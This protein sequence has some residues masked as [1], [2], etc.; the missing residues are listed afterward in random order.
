MDAVIVKVGMLVL[1]QFFYATDSS[2]K[3]ETVDANAP[4]VEKRPKELVGYVRG[5]HKTKGYKTKTVNG[6]VFAFEEEKIILDVLSRKGDLRFFINANACVPVG[7]K[8]EYLKEMESFNKSQEEAR[9]K[10]AEARRKN[11]EKEPKGK[12]SKKSTETEL[13]KQV[14][15]E[16]TASPSP[17][18]LVEPEQVVDKKPDEIQPEKTENKKTIQEDYDVQV[19]PESQEPAAVEEEEP[20]KAPE[21]KPGIKEI[22]KDIIGSGK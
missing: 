6:K 9:L 22:F 3:P 16:V 14:T 19:V 20:V 4:I 8:D 15:K 5:V 17:Q 2:V 13:L 1:C 10:N 11:A 18:Q 7:T 21:K 12:K